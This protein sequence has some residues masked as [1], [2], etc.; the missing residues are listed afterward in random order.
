MQFVP[1]RNVAD[2]RCTACGGCCKLYSVVIT[3]NEWLRIVKSYGVEQT[4]SDL[5]KLYIRRRGDGSCA[6]L[7]GFSNS[8]R[9]GLQHMKPRSCQIWPFKILNVPKYDYADEAAY[10]YGECKLFIYVDSMCS[11]IRYGSPTWEFAN[12]TLKEFVEIAV[13]VRN[14]QAKSTANVVFHRLPP[15]LDGLTMR[16]RL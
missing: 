12:Q 5:N 13:G 10:A 4:T 3:F 6:F 16:G 14:T 7:Y 8:C 2:W 1:W 11:G 9:C 15:Y